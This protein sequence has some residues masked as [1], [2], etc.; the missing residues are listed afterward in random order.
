MFSIHG[1][2][3]IEV[4]G[5]VVVQ[6][7]SGTWNEEAIIAYVKEF[8]AKTSPLKGSP[9]AIVSSFEDWE[10][11]VPAID[12]HI[13]EHCQWFKNNG[14]SKDCHIYTESAAKEMQLERLIPHTDASYE[15]QVFTNAEDASTWLASHGFLIDGLSINRIANQ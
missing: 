4:C 11:G 2:W 15:R 1:E 5:N 6:W 10:F 8:R 7:F 12:K 3:K 14:C 13:E 9:W